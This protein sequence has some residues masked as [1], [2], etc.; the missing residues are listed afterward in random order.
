M[1]DKV[2]PAS[3]RMPRSTAIAATHVAEPERQARRHVGTKS[4]HRSRL[5]PMKDPG[6]PMPRPLAA[7]VHTNWRRDG[8]AELVAVL[9]WAGRDRVGVNEI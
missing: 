6:T 9:V 7:S 4:T 8:G 2:P 1:T 3:I 5:S